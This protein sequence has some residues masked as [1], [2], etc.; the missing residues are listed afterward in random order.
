VNQSRAADFSPRF[1]SPAAADTNCEDS[2]RRA[3]DAS[4]DWRK[5]A[6]PSA[7]AA[8]DDIGTNPKGHAETSHGGQIAT[9][10]MGY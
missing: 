9:L 2:V 6:R 1:P 8:L 5:A 7:F 4:G 10:Q 3:I